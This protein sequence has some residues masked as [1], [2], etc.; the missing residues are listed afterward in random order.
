MTLL[1]SMIELNYLETKGMGKIQKIVDKL[2]LDRY[3]SSRLILAIDLIISLSASLVMSFMMFYWLK[4]YR[5]IIRHST[6]REFAKLCL[7]S[8]GKVV[9]MGALVMLLLF[10]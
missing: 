6:L 5:S 3:F 1:V 2:H 4:T 9:L 7:A 10:Q 8:L